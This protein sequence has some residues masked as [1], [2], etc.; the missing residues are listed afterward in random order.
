[1]KV[2]V[3]ICTYNRAE[4]LDRT[5]AG[6]HNLVIP[7]GV[8]W[9]LLVVDNHSTDRT[10][11]VI[12]RNAER[13]PIRRFFEPQ[14]G[15]SFAAN[16]ALSQAGG[17]LIL[18]TDDDVLVGPTWLS[19]YVRA[20][21]D[22]PDAGFFGGTVDPWF[23]REPPA[24]IREHFIVRGPYAVNQFGPEIRPMLPAESPH[25]A[26]M[27][28]RTRVARQFPYNERLGPFKRQY[29]PGEDGDLVVRMRKA[30]HTGVW[31]G[32]AAVKHFI[33]AER[34]T[35]DYIRD[36]YRGHG[37]T[38]AIRARAKAEKRIWGV[39]RWAIRRW[40]E[41]SCKACFFAVFTG[42][43]AKWAKAYVDALRTK[44]LIDQSWAQRSFP[45]ALADRTQRG[46]PRKR[47]REHLPWRVRKYLT[48]DRYI[49]ALTKYVFRKVLNTPPIAADANGQ[50][51]VLSLLDRGNVN[52]YLITI[53]SLLSNLPERPAVG[54]LSDGTLQPED[55]ATLKR[56]V[57]GMR[58]FTR[59]EVPLPESL[60][61]T[62]TD[63]C[64]AYPYLAKLL[65]LSLAS[66]AQRVMIV[67]SDVVFR[68]GLPADFGRLPPGV[69]ALYNCDHDHS[70]YDP[71][72]HY[73]EA[74]ARESSIAPIKNLNCGLMIWRRE[75]LRPLD[76]VAFLGHIKEKIGH[77]HA[78]AE[79]DA[80]SL[81]A[82][83]VR[84][85]PLPL[86][87]LVLS[88]WPY[89]TPAQRRQA[90]SVHYVRGERYR[91]FDYLRDGWNTIEMVRRLA[92]K[93]FMAGG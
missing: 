27:A 80:W 69:D 45:D 3:A 88:N 40:I 32:T 1:M 25:G 38:L 76:A 59:D 49:E 13:L 51:E 15:K 44:G 28:V 87:F 61:P 64:R 77:L 75:A 93:E 16:R 79:Q 8:E 55:I 46:A 39:P 30:G 34:L 17:D 78:V 60:R 37:R 90:L 63:W 92:G 54:V 2:S 57:P 89:N 18:W 23:E 19:E 73:L 56:H 50:L 22:W 12:A 41:S 91:R 71:C 52:N 68:P 4:L 24:W 33:S 66:T 58:V 81:L 5:L 26:N 53:K 65:F 31:V 14:E 72:F 74:F 67:D 35:Q 6:M 47:L 21:R 20:A 83:Q 9:E 82:S 85:Q 48:R 43:S 70:R 29:L 62:F 36:W 84:S 7:E 10:A 42:R 86:Q 11:D